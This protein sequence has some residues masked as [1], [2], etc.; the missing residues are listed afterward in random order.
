M[1]LQYEY[2]ATG[3]RVSMFESDIEAKSE[4]LN[5]RIA[6]SRIAIVG[7]AGSIGSSVVKTLLRFN[8][9]GLTLIDLSENNLVELVREL[10]SDGDVKLPEDFSTMPIGMGS[11]EFGRFFAEQEN[12]D[13]F[14]NLAALKHVRSE[15][16]VYCLARMID[17]NVLFMHEFLESNPYKFKKVFS[18]SSDK[19]ANPANLMGASKMLMEQVLLEHSDRQEFST[20]RFANVAFSDGSLPYGFLERIAK[21]QPL[22]APSDIRR[23]F[24]SHREAGELCVLSCMC[25]ENRD[26][27]FPKMSSGKDE[28]T[29][30]EIAMMLLDSLGYKVELCASESEARA[31]AGELIEQKKWPCCFLPAD[32]DGEKS[33]EEFFTSDEKVD[34]DFLPHIGVIKRNGSEYDP[35]QLRKFIEFAQVARRDPRVSKDDYIREMSLAVPGLEHAMTGKNLDQKM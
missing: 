27:F 18:V 22:E 11:I 19:A 35:V 30:A 25:G 15:K 34:L 28:K 14:F 21:R 33:Y 8:P 20:A 12:F 1:N 17:T 31:R 4:V 26:V 5:D 3:R 32:T 24:I 10:R 9:A 13:Y 7:A 23:Y 29:F 2:I 16:N 6:G